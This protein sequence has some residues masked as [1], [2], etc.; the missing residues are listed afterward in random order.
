MFYR[1]EDL[2]ENVKEVNQ[3]SNAP[4]AKKVCNSD[5]YVTLFT[6]LGNN[7]F[8]FFSCLYRRHG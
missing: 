8:M 7:D 5:L 6:R 2:Q 1:S 3:V 4:E